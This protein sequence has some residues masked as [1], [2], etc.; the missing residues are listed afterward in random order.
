MRQII[1]SAFLITLLILPQ[2]GLAWG[3][4]GHRITGQIAVKY[5]TPAARQ[6]VETLM[7]GQSLAQISTWADE[8]RS[9]PEWSPRGER[10]P[11]QADWRHRHNHTKWHYATAPRPEDVAKLPA[12][13]Y[14]INDGY[15]IPKLIQC[16]A[17]LRDP[18]AKRAQKKQ[19][20]AFLVHFI[21]DLHQPLHVGNGKDRGGNAVDVKWF[22]DETNLHSVWD[23]K[24]IESQNLSHTE[25]TDFLLRKTPAEDIQAWQQGDY[26]DWARESV[27]FRSQTYLFNDS[28]QPPKLSYNYAYDQRDL[29]EQR[30]V[31]AGLRMAAKLNQIFAE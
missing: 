4:V 20:L 27:T 30:L 24:M 9:D 31:Q 11:R 13:D 3:A 2:P 5:L 12:A 14:P 25:Y 16:E 10:P 1:F 17:T 7:D 15:L 18:N 23:S 19:A 26:L 29:M 6:A 22:N 8:I 21:G 28:R